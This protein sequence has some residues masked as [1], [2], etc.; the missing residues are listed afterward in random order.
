M[1]RRQAYRRFCAPMFGIAAATFG[2]LMAGSAMAQ[3][4]IHIRSPWG[5]VTATLSN[6]LAAQNLYR[7]LP[8][9]LETTDHL[10]QEKVGT[11]PEELPETP[12]V[13]PFNAGTLGIWGSN[14]FVI[15]YIKGQVPPPGIMIVG[16]VAGDISFLDRPG[17]VTV[18]VER[19][20]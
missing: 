13:L 18:R 12:R 17:P 9:T 8:L 5:D 19:A 4:K 1:L 2:V 11:L 20:E 10:R 16:E 14:R 6:N 7:M 3:Q 15:Y